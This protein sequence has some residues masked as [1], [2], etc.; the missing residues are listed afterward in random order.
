[1]QV[2]TIRNLIFTQLL[3]ACIFAPVTVQAAT[4]VVFS[5]GKSINKLVTDGTKAR[6][7][8]GSG[9]YVLIDYPS[10]SV[11]MVSPSVKQIIDMGAQVPATA[12]RKIPQPEITL[13]RKGSGPVIAGYQTTAYEWLANGRACGTLY[14]SPDA[15][16]VSGMQ[17][18]FKALRL[19]MQRQRQAMGAYAAMMSV[20]KQAQFSISDYIQKT[21]IPM[22]TVNARGEIE[23][24]V[25]SIKTGVTLAT[26]AFTPPP[27]YK[28]VS[29]NGDI[30]HV[31]NDIEQAKGDN[32]Q[33]LQG[34]SP[35]LQQV[36]QQLQRMQQSGQLP[37][38]AMEQ[39]QRYQQM[40]QQH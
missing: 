22:R 16:K 12:S 3:V 27:S 39:L 34:M 35:E 6:I 24:E 33:L 9:E 7:G 8:M 26:N 13:T 2:K 19:M 11:Q 17:S 38:Q 37:P 30:N 21:G 4:E 20:C 36:Q 29:M 25:Q 14:G 10:R 1:M 23:T 40:M 18:L 28:K 32:R 5:D 31:E 15:L